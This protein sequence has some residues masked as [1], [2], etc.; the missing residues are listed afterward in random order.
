L[1]IILLNITGVENQLMPLGLLL[2]F[3]ISLYT[4]DNQEQ[5]QTPK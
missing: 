5:A 3:L 1:L 4:K 2:S